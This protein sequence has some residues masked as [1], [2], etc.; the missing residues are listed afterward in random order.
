MRKSYRSFCEKVRLPQGVDR[1][2]MEATYEDGLLVVRMPRAKV[3]TS[4]R[5][6]ITVN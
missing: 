4:K 6:K 2:A 3:E 1:E 5:H